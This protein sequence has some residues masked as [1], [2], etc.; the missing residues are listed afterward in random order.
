MIKFA[1]NQRFT[2]KL[3]LIFNASIS[4][5][6]VKIEPVL[7]YLQSFVFPFYNATESC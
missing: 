5:K 2:S 1:Q 4:F 7:T 3:G 6:R